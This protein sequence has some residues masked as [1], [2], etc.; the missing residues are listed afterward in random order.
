M[1]R[2]RHV[3]RNGFRTRRFDFDELSRC[4]DPLVADAGEVDQLLDRVAARD[5]RGE[6]GALGDDR[7]SRSAEPP[8]LED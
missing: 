4:I 7:T 5:G 1:N 3:A 8:N 6:L 2:N